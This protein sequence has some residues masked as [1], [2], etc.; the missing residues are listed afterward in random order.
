MAAR[1][2]WSAC[3]PYSEQASVDCDAVLRR[4]KL[5]GQKDLRCTANVGRRRHDR[6][7]VEG[8]A[9]P[10]VWGGGLLKAGAVGQQKGGVTAALARQL[11]HPSL[12]GGLGLQ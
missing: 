8:G 7:A 2:R 10:S 6:G 3:W 4:S 12:L 9:D 11:S 1:E 5:G